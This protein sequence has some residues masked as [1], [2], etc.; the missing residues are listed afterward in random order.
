M[1]LIVPAVLLSALCAC[2]TLP[3]D[4]EGLRTL[5]D[6]EIVYSDMPANLSV[7]VNANLDKGVAAGVFLFVSMA[8]AGVLYGVD[9]HLEHRAESAMRDHDSVI[10]GLHFRETLLAHTRAAIQASP[11]AAHVSFHAT[12]YLTEDVSNAE[13]ELLQSGK[14][15]VIFMWPGV[16]LDDSGRTLTVTMRVVIYLKVNDPEHHRTTAVLYRMHDFSYSYPLMLDTKP[17]SWEQQK[18]N[19]HE[20]ASMPVER[21]MQTWLDNSTAQVR[22][23]FSDAQPK[24]EADLRGFLSSPPAA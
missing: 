17:G 1:R 16:Y 24:I 21:A 14:D 10:D 12:D 8:G 20:L 19:A 22:T 13:Q 2:T 3:L 23:D 18:Q 7:Y 9:K 6:T 11:W 4:Q 5:G 15:S